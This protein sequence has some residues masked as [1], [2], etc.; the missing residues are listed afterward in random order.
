MKRTPRS[1]KRRASRQLEAKVPGFLASSPYS[2]KCWPV[3]WRFRQFGHR[4]LHPKRHF[5]LGDAGVRFGIAEF[6]VFEL[7]EFA[8]SSQDIRAG[9][10]AETLRDLR[11]TERDRRLNGISRLDSGWAESRCPTGGHTAAG[12]R[13]WRNHH[14]EGREVFGFAADAVGD[15]GAHAGP[16]AE[17]EAGLRHGDGGIVI[18]LFG[19][20]RLDEGELVGN[21]GG[22]REQLANPRAGVAVLRE[23]EFRWDH[24]ERRLRG[25]HAGESLAAA[26][27]FR[28]VLCPEIPPGAA[29]NRTTPSATV[30]RIEIDR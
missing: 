12:R 17:A 22:V 16:A 21:F 19:V 26:D 13:R 5:V 6:L 29:C 7:V 11:C 24:R 30:R 14:D 2:S 9:V 27:R 18:D 3:L 20:H 15:P 1:A 10:G 23:F 28:K 25:G 8:E 4:S